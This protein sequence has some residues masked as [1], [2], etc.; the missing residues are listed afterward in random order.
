MRLLNCSFCCSNFSSSLADKDHDT[1]FPSKIPSAIVRFSV[2]LSSPSLISEGRCDSSTDFDISSDLSSCSW[3]LLFF[4]TWT[5]ILSSALSWSSSFSKNFQML[6]FFFNWIP[7]V[8]SPQNM[9]C[10]LGSLVWSPSSSAVKFACFESRF[11]TTLPVNC[12]AELSST[13]LET[14]AGLSQ[15]TCF[16]SRSL[17][18]LST[19]TLSHCRS[20]ISSTCPFLLTV[21]L[22]SKQSTLV[23]TDSMLDVVSSVVEEDSPSKLSSE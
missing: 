9:D 13:K 3:S 11:S 6:C 4:G 18:C 21:V 1:S 12:S 2:S 5:L 16:S 15:G 14:S 22:L 23:L 10:S 19:L 17:A 20:W 7:A 8:D